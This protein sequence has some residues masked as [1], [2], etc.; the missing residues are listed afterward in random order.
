MMLIYLE[1]IDNPEDQAKFA[2]LY[3]KYEKLMFRITFSLLRNHHDAEDAMHDAFTG[4]A[5]NMKSIGNPE[6]DE[7]R[8]YVSIAAEHAAL[9][10]RKKRSKRAETELPL[11]DLK[12]PGAD[13]SGEVNDELSLC[14][15]KLPENY[16]TMI[17][18]KYG[19]GYS[20]KEVAKMMGISDSNAS[21]L[22]Q[23]AKASLEKICR[24][25]GILR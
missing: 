16:R 6:S 18:L 23:R 4:I 2:I 22:D 15:L 12:L 17:M 21:K 5:K 10:L 19:Y 9:N 13:W 8:G 24:E 14:I 3:E 1:M 11:K 7:T 20:T 25:A